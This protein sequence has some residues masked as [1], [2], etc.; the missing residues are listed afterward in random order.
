MTE[1]QTLA[2]K[3]VVE[4]FMALV[5]ERGADGVEVGDIAQH[6]N[7]PLFELRRH[8]D[9]PLD[10]LEAFEREIDRQVLERVPD[11]L[12]QDP[13]RERIFDVLMMRFDAF[14]PYKP[15]LKEL[16]REARRNPI[17]LAAWNRI[18]V[19]SQYWMLVAAGL[20]PKGARG[21]AQAQGM[22]FVFGR[23]FQVWLK[24]DDPGMARTMAELDRR[25]RGAER[26]MRRVRG[27]SR[28]AGPLRF[29]T[30]RRQR[31]PTEPAAEFDDP[32]YHES[33]RTTH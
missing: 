23:A 14:M 15:A 5:A 33:S 26:N 32:P 22:V 25:L 20:S 8:M 31:Y 19:R 1:A 11:E 28:L 12:M 2:K 13:P 29:L 7:V 4:A 6:L 27:L 18:A 9:T 24:D 30:R 17:F 3:D 16:F 21:M 10:L